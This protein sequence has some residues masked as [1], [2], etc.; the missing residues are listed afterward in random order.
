MADY[1]IL[2]ADLKT[3]VIREE[4]PFTDFSYSRVLCRAGA[5]TGRLPYTHP[6]ATLLNI[7][8]KQIA[9]YVERDGVIVYGGIIWTARVSGS[10]LL[11][12][13]SEG[14][15][16]Y[17]NRRLI[18]HTI[19]LSST[20]QLDIARRILNDAQSATLSPGGS[21]NLLI[22]SDLS[23]VLRQRT[24]NAFERKTVSTAVEELSALDNGFDFR[25][26]C[27]W[28]SNAITKRLRWGYPRLGVRGGLVFELGGNAQAVA[29]LLDGSKDANLVDAVGAGEGANMLISTASDPSQLTAF[30][31]LETTVSFKDVTMPDTLADH[32]IAALAAR[33]GSL[34][35]SNV[36]IRTTTDAPVGS[37][38]VGDDVR[39]RADDGFLQIDSLY[40]IVSDQ[41]KVDAQGNEDVSIAFSGSEQ[42]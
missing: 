10:N 5:F 30:P 20:D 38:T 41:V 21:I 1:R 26:D 11:E 35:L 18:R 27:Q 12:V 4:I 19:D 24:Y 32:A 8:P 15:W 22:D 25:V 2:V 39:I 31:L 29:W 36:V 33:S 34:G 6:K 14:F 17:F 37:W 7:N 42:F 9:L 23:G 13:G 3:N 40:R 16:S 28:E